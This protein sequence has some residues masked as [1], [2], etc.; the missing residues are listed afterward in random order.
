MRKSAIAPIDKGEAAFVNGTA[1]WISQFLLAHTECELSHHVAILVVAACQCMALPDARVFYGS[2][3]K[4][5]RAFSHMMAD[6]LKVDRMSDDG[7]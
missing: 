7:E 4:F 5:H 1:D 2:E 3:R 6:I